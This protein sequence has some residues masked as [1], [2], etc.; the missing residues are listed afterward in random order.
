M[1]GADIRSRRWL[2]RAIRIRAFPRP[3]GELVANGQG[4]RVQ[5]AHVRQLAQ[6]CGTPLASRS[7]A[8]T[9]TALPLG[10]P[11]WK[12]GMAQSR[13]WHSSEQKIARFRTHDLRKI[14]VYVSTNFR[15]ILK[16]QFKS[17]L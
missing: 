7:R 15:V 17:F 9:T 13:H 4:Y 2:W 3:I 14:V 12:C 1:L 11:I 16:I 10:T 5:L 6:L 8:V